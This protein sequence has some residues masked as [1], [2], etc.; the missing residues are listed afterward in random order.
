[1]AGLVDRVERKNGWQLAEAIGEVDAKGAQRL[2]NAATWDADAVRPRCL[3]GKLR[4]YVVEHLEDEASGFPIV[5]ETGF[6]KKGTKSC[7]IARRN[8]HG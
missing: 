3:L 6:P 1:M 8:A 2:L 5:D 7:G 4:D